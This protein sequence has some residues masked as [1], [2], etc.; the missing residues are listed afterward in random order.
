MSFALTPTYED[1]PRLQSLVERLRDYLDGELAEY[2]AELGLTQESHYI[3]ETLEPVWRRSRE[4]G[5]YGIHLPTELGGQN[6][7]FTELAAL[8]EE[9]GASPRVLATSVLGDMGGPLRAGSIFQYATEHQLEKYLIPVLRG[10]KACCFSLTENDA[11]S[12]VRGM[13]TTATP[14]GAGWR[15]NGHKVFSSAGP[16][17]DFSVLIAKMASDGD[18]PD[19][20]SAFLVDL[21]SPGCTVADG[22]VPMSGQHIEAD[23]ILDGCYVGPEQLLGNVGEGLRIGLGRVTVNRLLH[24]PTVLGGARRALELSL[25][26]SK[27]RQV[28]GAP[29]AMLQSIQHKLADMA[30]D[31]YAARSMTYDA[32]ATLDAGGSPRTEAFMCKLFVAEKAFTIAD[33]AVQIHGKAGVIRG[34]EV[35]SLFQRLRMFRILTGSSEIQKNGIARQL[36][37]T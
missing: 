21:D 18:G 9:V 29:L 16:F 17:A 34:S 12:D 30:T 37:T 23:I 4:L 36:L 27:T 33:H 25:E 19:S 6:L 13:L 3:R 35:E 20:Y 5:F 22:D 32:L 15:L 24:C 1:N 2:E 14:D 8:K 7:T 10:E 26:Y 31:Y 28:Q 11:G